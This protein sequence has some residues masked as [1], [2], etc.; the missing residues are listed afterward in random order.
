[1]N[2]WWLATLT[3]VALGLLVLAVRA[4]GVPGCCVCTGLSC[5]PKVCF[6][7]STDCAA[8]CA[9]QGC[10]VDAEHAGQ[11][12]GDPDWCGGANPTPAPTPT[13]CPQTACSAGTC[14]VNSLVDTG[15]GC[16][17]LE[18]CSILDALGQ[19]PTTIVL[20]A[21]TIN[22]DCGNTWTNTSALT[23]I[24]AGQGLTIIDAGDACEIWAAAA[25]L[26]LSNLTMQ[27]GTRAVVVSAGATT[28]TNVTLA[29]NTSPSLSG[30]GIECEGTA[31][32]L[33]HVS[34][35][36]NTA[37]GNTVGGCMD[38]ESGV[39]V[40]TNSTISGNS[41]SSG[42]GVAVSNDAAL[43]I[44]NSTISGN[45]AVSND[46]GGVDAC[47]TGAVVIANTTIANNTAA[48]EFR[49]GGFQGLC[50]GVATFT[51]VT[52]GGNT[53]DGSP[54]DVGVYDN[55]LT[56]TNSLVPGGCTFEFAPGGTVITGSHNLDGGTSCGWGAGSGNLQNSDPLLGSLADNGGPTQTMALQAGSPALDAGDDATCAPSPV[57][58]VDQRGIARP[59]GAH[60][61]MGAYEVVPPTPTPTPHGTPLS[62]CLSSSSDAQT[63]AATDASYCG[64]TPTPA[65]GTLIAE[66]SFDAGAYTTSTAFAKWTV[67]TDLDWRT[68]TAARLR[69]TCAE[70]TITDTGDTTGAD[71]MDWSTDECFAC[72]NPDVVIGCG[73]APFASTSAMQVCSDGVGAFTLVSDPLEQPRVSNGLV[74]MAWEMHCNGQGASDCDGTENPPTGINRVAVTADNTLCLDLWTERQTPNDCTEG[75]AFCPLGNVAGCLACVT[76]LLSGDCAGEATCVGGGNCPSPGC[77]LSAGCAAAVQANCAVEC[78][79]AAVETPTATATATPTA[80]NT[81]TPSPTPAK[82]TGLFF[83]HATCASP[84]CDSAD[85]FPDRGPHEADL[86]GGRKTVWMRT[87]AGSATIT[88]LGRVSSD[89]SWTI[90]GTLTGATCTTL[91]H[92]ELTLTAWTD[93]LKAEIS[94]CTDCD[95]SAGWR[96]E[97]RDR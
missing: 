67:G 88:I 77:A 36:R 72:E 17:T 68:I 63:L 56:V 69:G 51:N 6:D 35:T 5:D 81:F 55:G 79:C 65:L 96:Q 50:G 48:A 29:D 23:I 53:I 42:G 64:G 2:R 10:T 95:V 25:D 86:G 76:P 39:G 58:G 4:W 32:T 40:I 92:C 28:L 27:H 91:S 1:M 90:F 31:C 70:S 84:P 33:D 49:G 57:S 15:D 26:A 34:C 38:I 45:S 24:G 37:S 54:N 97:R 78:N 47:T 83:W 71:Y 19:T 3:V 62:Y 14:T 75:G 52:F 59:Q 94:A 43:T 61:D 21:G 9:G 87:D 73:S 20:P 89:G 11:I 66:R 8:D 74:Q 30:A 46:G 82:S 44:T 12:C 7:N 18:D 13:T 22:R 16:C 85:A 93:D 80:T 41:A 60:C